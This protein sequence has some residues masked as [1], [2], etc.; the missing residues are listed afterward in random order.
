MKQSDYERYQE[1]IASIKVGGLASNNEIWKEI[2]KIKLRY[3]GM[4]PKP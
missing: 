1:L 4:P 2:E 3:G